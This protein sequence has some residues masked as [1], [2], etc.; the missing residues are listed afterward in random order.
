M[1]ELKNE[2]SAIL[3]NNIKKYR[4][5]NMMSQTELAKKLGLS[6]NA[7]CRYENGDRDPSTQ[8]I[9]KLCEVL[10]VDFNELYNII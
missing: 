7:I 3:G 6:Q 8:I 5:M 10:Q 1:C 4:Q 2:Y 9:Y